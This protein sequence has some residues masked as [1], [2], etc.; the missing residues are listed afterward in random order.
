M[1]AGDLTTVDN[2]KIYLGA[3]T[4]NEDDSLFG[5]LITFAS[6]DFR[7]R[8]DRDIRFPDTTSYTDTVTGDGSQ[9]LYLKQYPVKEITSVTVDSTVI[10][11]RTSLTATGWMLD[12]SKGRL[13]LTG[14]TFSGW[15]R[16]DC[17]PFPFGFAATVS[18]NVVVVYK[19]GYATLPYDVEQAV[20][21]MV[22]MKFR[23]RKNIGLQS[24]T[25]GGQSVAY[26]PSIL[27]RSVQDVIDFYSRRTT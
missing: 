27:P 13:D 8:T 16:F 7:R 6:D 5:R 18:N 12:K 1:A 23:E 14:Y 9:V 21:E 20:I 17:G 25:L 11:E 3:N 15:G 24:Q 19:A 4:G 26:L 10:P 22:G 2:V